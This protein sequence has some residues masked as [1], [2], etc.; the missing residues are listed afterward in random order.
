MLLLLMMMM[1]MMMMWRLGTKRRVSRRAV[2]LEMEITW[3]GVS[4]GPG[5][6]DGCTS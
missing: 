5:L 6:V 1:M 4:T 3:Y 2:M